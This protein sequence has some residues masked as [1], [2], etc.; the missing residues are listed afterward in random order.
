MGEEPEINGREK[1]NLAGIFLF[2]IMSLLKGAILL[3]RI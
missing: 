1:L 3:I 2:R